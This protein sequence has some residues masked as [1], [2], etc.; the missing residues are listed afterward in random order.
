MKSIRINHFFTLNAN[1]TK[2]SLSERVIR[3]GFWVF[4][5]RFTNRGFGFVRKI[6]LARLLAP[7]DFGLLGIAFLSIYTLET[8]SETGFQSALVQKKTDINPYLD[9]AWT[10]CAIRGAILFGLLFLAA[11]FIAEFFGSPQATLIIRVIGV[12]ILL[13]GFKNIGVIFFQKDLEFNK[14]FSYQ[15]S[16]TLTNF[17][18][19]I[20]LALERTCSEFCA[21]FY[22]I[23]CPSISAQTQI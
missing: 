18:M 11:P 12:T 20:V 21:A 16:G 17:G 23:Y 14:E 10:V 7:E 1:I 15:F 6:V 9:T 4:A 5:L 13:S 3:S 22:V 19:S 2:G 8:F